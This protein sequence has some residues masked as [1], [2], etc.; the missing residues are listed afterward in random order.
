MVRGSEASPAAEAKRAPLP[1]SIQLWTCVLFHV[2]FKFAIN[3]NKLL[4]TTGW[5]FA[6]IIFSPQ[7]SG[8]FN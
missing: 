2:P 5:G 6:G 7:R 4:K 1:F 8:L 3:R